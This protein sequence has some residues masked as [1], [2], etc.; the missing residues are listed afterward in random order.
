MG[1]EAVGRRR[2][3]FCRICLISRAGHFGRTSQTS[4]VAALVAAKRIH[5]GVGLQK[6][7]ALTANCS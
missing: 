3:R 7:V 6:A 4:N 2:R 1:D 5:G